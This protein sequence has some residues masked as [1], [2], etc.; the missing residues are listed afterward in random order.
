MTYFKGAKDTL[1]CY[2]K[3]LE[4]FFSK[5]ME[6][7]RL[8]QLTDYNINFINMKGGNSILADVIYRLKM[9]GIYKDLVKDPK[10]PQASE[11]QVTE[12]NT[13]KIYTLD[14]NVLCVEQ[15]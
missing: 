4:P 2:H 1:Y 5:G 10:K 9:L 7:L 6:R 8:N 12:V 3:H 13:S 11:I 14:S 15:K